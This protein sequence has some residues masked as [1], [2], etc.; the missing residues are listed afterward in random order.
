MN[1][2]GESGRTIE[3]Y[4]LVGETLPTNAKLYRFFFLTGTSPALY[5]CFSAGV[6]TLI[7][8]SSG[9][10]TNLAGT[11]SLNFGSIDDCS[12]A[13]LT[14]ALVGARVT[15]YIAT[16]R[17]AGLADGV[18]MTAWCSAS[19]VISVMLANLSGAA[20]DPGA[21]TYGVSCVR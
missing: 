6:W 15:D 10:P 16:L 19:D 13:I 17:P 5:G 7:A 21:L 20:Y 11:A 12:Y 8:S 14:F 4:M 18:I 9:S 2:V 1:Q 3:R